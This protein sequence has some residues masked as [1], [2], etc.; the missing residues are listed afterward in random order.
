MTTK[1][2]LFLLMTL[3]T[4]P[5][6]AQIENH[7]NKDL[8]LREKNAYLRKMNVGNYNPNTD[9]YDL[10]YQRLELTI[11]PAQRYV[12]GTVASHFTPKENMSSIYFDLNKNLKVSEV[13]YKGNAL[14]FTQLNSHELK[15]DFQSPLA[16]GKLDSLEVKYYGVP[17]MGQDAV[18]TTPQPDGTPVFA[19][20]NEPYGAQDWFPTKQSLNDKIEK[21][22]LFITTPKQYSV[23]AN[24]AFMAETILP[25]GQK[26]TK[27]RSQYPIAS[28][29]IALG[30][31]KYTKL[32]DTIGNPPF[33]FIN[34]V[35]PSTTQDAYTMNVIDW[36]K[37]A[38][39]L[40]E[41]HFGPYPFRNEKYGHMQYNYNGVAMEHQTMSSMPHWDHEVTAHELAHQ[42]FGNKITCGAW[43][44]IWLNEGFAVFGEHLINE[45]LLLSPSQFQNYLSSIK[46]SITSQPGG[47]VYVSDN[48]ITNIDAI[49]SWRLSYQKS[50]FIVRMMKWKLGDELFYSAIRDYLNHPDLAYGYARTKDLK[51]SLLASTNV[52]FT[53][54]FNDWVYGEGYPIYTIRW[55]QFGNQLIIQADQKQSHSSVSFYEMPLPIRIKGNGGEEKDIRL[56]HTASG[57]TFTIPVDFTVS[58]IEFN[59]NNQILERNHKV[60]QDSQLT[61]TEVKHLELSVY[62]NPVKNEI[63]IRGLTAKSQYT[64]YSIDGKKVTTGVLE[65]ARPI[66][67]NGL[68]KGKYFI[69]IHGQSFSFIKE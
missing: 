59:Y 32:L 28:Y 12:K 15:V 38:M 30:I 47:S 1:N 64:V 9:N 42:W 25:S 26:L 67:V 65:P 23:A 41:T 63:F 35:Y 60:V 4:V 68:P 6:Y 8:L 48:N 62:P 16:S 50:G 14:S 57:Q 54:F 7:E 2:L 46:N 31:T 66:S 34:Y 19:T 58:K 52:D 24:G 33:P 43:N 45:K 21:V 36:T 61:T 55:N 53:E 22:D 56:E 13:N 5:F 37:Q 17:P 18:R 27:W 49:F 20:L 10:R 29:L 51:N 11:D 39:S 40:F 69:T 44:D 3:L